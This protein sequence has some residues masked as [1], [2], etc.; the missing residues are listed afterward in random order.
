MSTESPFSRATV[1]P[2]VAVGFGWAALCW[3]LSNAGHQ[4]RGPTPLPDWYRVQAL[5]VPVLVPALGIFAGWLARRVT[6]GT[7][8]LAAEVA[9]SIAWPL[10]AF[11]FVDAL[12]YSLGGFAALAPAFLVA[13]PLAVLAAMGSAG[14][15]VAAHSAHTRPY[16][17]G[18]VSVVLALGLGAPLLR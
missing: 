8:R 15:A 4:P 7:E 1:L 13:G 11:V 3:Q 14:R 12:T 10:G 17:V 5:L 18:A 6:G 16:V 9:R 2:L